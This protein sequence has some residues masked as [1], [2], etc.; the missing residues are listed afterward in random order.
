[1]PARTLCSSVH[2]F[3]RRRMK[4]EMTPTRS[5]TSRSSTT[6][7]RSHS[8]WSRERGQG[9][10]RTGDPAVRHHGPA[11]PAVALSSR[12]H[13]GRRRTAFASLWNRS[14]GRRSRGARE[15]HD[16]RAALGSRVRSDA[17]RHRRAEDHGPKPGVPPTRRAV[18]DDASSSLRPRTTVNLKFATRS[19][20]AEAHEM[21]GPPFTAPF[22]LH[23]GASSASGTA[24]R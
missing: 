12:R 18:E 16:R 5:S 15:R 8:T 24:T 13:Q 6:V 9:H 2:Q 17:S 3:Q 23:D 4:K 7:S 14:P 21:H 22:P 20:R 19:S 11:A 1:M 10:P